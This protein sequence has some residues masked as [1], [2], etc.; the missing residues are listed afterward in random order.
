MT[1]RAAIFDLDGTLL[2]TLT[3]LG[4][5]MNRVLKR[6]DFPEHPITAYKTFV[7]EGISVL[8]R[9][10]LPQGKNDESLIGA[11]V[12]AMSIE[13]TNRCMDATKPYPDIVP[14]LEA[15]A[16]QEIKLAIL[17]NKPHAMTKLLAAHYFP[18]TPFNCV[19][20][21]RDGVPKKPHPLG[22]LEIARHIEIDPDD[23]LFVGDS[24]IDM[25]TATF[26]GMFPVGAL[27]G[28]REKHEL[29]T[30][31][32]RKVIEHPLELLSVIDGE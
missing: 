21:A 15:L 13:Y 30:H 18:Q 10:A 14:L 1:M 11:T 17:S 31:G 23:F 8:A 28:F 7:G 12:E 4:T 24:G 9:R 19:I 16:K 5:S 32:A 29:L 27:W 3:D 25:D 6:M 2:D 22:A 26:A 20:G